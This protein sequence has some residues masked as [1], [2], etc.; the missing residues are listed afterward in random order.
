MCNFASHFLEGIFLHLSF[1][2]FF[3]LYFSWKYPM[4]I[5]WLAVYPFCWDWLIIRLI[6]SIFFSI[7]EHCE[8]CIF[9]H[10]YDICNLLWLSIWSSFQL[11][12]NALI[13]KNQRSLMLRNMHHHSEIGVKC[14]YLFNLADRQ[15]LAFRSLLD[16]HR[17]RL[18][19][20][21]LLLSVCH[22]I[23]CSF[24]QYLGWVNFDNHF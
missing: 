3:F 22:L 5:Y 15:K 19:N 24:Y 2:S 10:I 18:N 8:L 23:Y 16:M 9:I 13:N 6:G 1:F 7:V 11:D 14:K 21:C 17:W 20:P 12:F 4:N